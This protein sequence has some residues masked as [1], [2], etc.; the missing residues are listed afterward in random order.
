MPVLD[1]VPEGDWTC[2]VCRGELGE[3][4]LMDMEATLAA[5]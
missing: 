3:E 1:A 5:T 2:A 4:D